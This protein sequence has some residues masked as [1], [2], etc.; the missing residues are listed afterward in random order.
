M[1]IL[2]ISNLYPPYHTS[3]YELGCQDI[4]ESL[5]AREHQIKVL[6]S[7]YGLGYT[8][9]EA[10]IHRELMGN[11]K[12]SIGWTAV[13]LKECVNQTVFK[14][15]CR[16]FQP[17][18][19][20]FFNLTHI[21]ASIALLAQEMGLST[22]HYFA[23]N[24]FITLEKDHWYQL[25]PKEG[26]RYRILRLLTRHYKLI[27]PTQPLNPA[28][29]IFANRYL[30]D[31]AVQLGKSSPDASVVPWGIDTSRFPYKEQKGQK[32][33]R[34]LYV[35][36]IKP[37]KGLENV[38]KALEL[39]NLEY[40][41][42]DLSMTFAGDEKSSPHYVT[43]L[44]NLANTVGVRNSIH[45]NGLTS[46]DDMTGLYHSHDILVSPSSCEASSNI[47]LL[48]AMSSGTA[49][50]STVT[51][52][53]R[54]ILEAE[55]NA[56]V[57]AKENPWSC[58]EQINRF[59][60]DPKRMNSIRTNA[61]NTV[62]KNFHIERS[63]QSIERILEEAF[64]QGKTTPPSQSFG[65]RPVS[66]EIKR[67]KSLTALV[68]Q[69]KIWLK[70]GNV[71][72]FV[73]NWSRPQVLFHILRRIF[74]KTTPFLPILFF[75]I[76]YEGFFVLTGRR[77][78]ISKKDPSQIKKIL[79]IQLADIGDIILTSPFL[80][81]LR[82]YLPHVWIT[83]IV[84]PRMF[85]LVEK[86]PYINEV[87]AF[88]W[89]AVKNWDISFNGCIHWWLQ[90][91]GVA[92]RSLWKRHLNMAIS[93]RWNS[94]PC[95]AASI[96]LMYMSGASLRI[97]YTDAPQDQRRYW[98]KGLD[99]FLTQGP[100]R[101]FP[102][103][104]VIRQLDILRFLGANP[105]DSGLEV[106]TTQ[107]DEFFA[108]DVLNRFNL[109]GTDLLIA[110]APGATWSFR[111]WPS[112]RFIELGKWL[113]ENYR[114]SILLLGGKGEQKLAHRIESGMH[115]RQTVNLAGKTTLREMASVLKHCKLFIG[116]DSGPLHVATAA[117]VSV[118]GLF[119]P[120]EYERFKP[121]G[122][123][124]EAI[125]LGLSCSPCSQNCLF[126]EPRC[127]KGITVDQVKRVLSKKLESLLPLS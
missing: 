25:W 27:P 117:G 65:R 64:R 53:N 89:R 73:R 17:D 87:L 76:F 84:Q 109:A 104:E 127:I 77:R 7:T 69:T 54:D 29:S 40:G 72:V 26:K 10:H 58:A 83:L 78:K 108:Q 95:Q 1:R 111:R 61:R 80:R 37:H 6:T 121:W 71:A 9:I 35:G 66:I 11:T 52:G 14:R 41:Y 93:T 94:D 42:H 120:G 21:S 115:R 55:I 44:R 28:Q 97:G 38:I 81:E 68:S 85:N 46:R 102:Q 23:N 3:G 34:L 75:P 31:I 39:L 106:W 47:A 103:H 90:S 18:V 51:G 86:C 30:K 91:V 67:E 114:A 125:C 36:Q 123:N 70:F 4:V 112:S 113:Q 107:E 100:I 105:V 50:V 33:C 82:R 5:K 56:L 126:D 13:F 62:E 99:R 59:L 119:G 2:V 63:A 101:G 79:V 116:N 43:H 12:G 74:E 48:E 124:H 8:K 92:K 118:V 16:D 98:L 57:F 15:T 60:K 24:W 22:C 32:S 96:I 19:I 110:F 20:F 88:D 45:F 49:V 122:A